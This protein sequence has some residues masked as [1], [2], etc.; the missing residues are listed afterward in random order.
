MYNLSSGEGPTFAAF[1]KEMTDHI[2]SLGPNPLGAR[3]DA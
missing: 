2:K 3:K 1:A